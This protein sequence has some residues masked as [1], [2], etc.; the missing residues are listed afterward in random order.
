VLFRSPSTFDQVRSA[1]IDSVKCSFPAAL[2]ATALAIPIALLRARYPSRRSFLLERLPYI[3]YAT[4]ALAFALSLILVCLW[5][6]PDGLQ[7]LGDALY[8]SLPLL[9][10]AYALHFLA[11]AV[12]PIRSSLYLAGPRLEEASRALGCGRWKTF[13]RVT[14]PA[15]RHGLIVAAALVFLSCMKELPLTMLLSPTGTTTLATEVWSNSEEGNYA[16]VAPFALTILVFSAIFVGVLLL[17]GRER[18]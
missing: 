1:L 4:P 9:V 18:K 6:F 16:K 8:H 11:E 15:L 12:G 5:G 17:Q 10:Y 13:R 2:L 3:G 14:V 7:W